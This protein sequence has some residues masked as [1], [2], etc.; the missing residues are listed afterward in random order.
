MLI[1]IIP[2]DL[3]VLIV[4]SVYTNRIFLKIT[5]PTIV[6]YLSSRTYG[7][8]VVNVGE[9]LLEYA[10]TKKNNFIKFPP[11]HMPDHAIKTSKYPSNKDGKMSYT[12]VISSFYIALLWDLVIVDWEINRQNDKI[13]DIAKY[14]KIPWKSNWWTKSFF[15]II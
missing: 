2:H 5:K 3:K 4:V 14:V 12:S 11:I 15:L 7:D 1:T 6:I 13:N 9:K 10:V 8:K